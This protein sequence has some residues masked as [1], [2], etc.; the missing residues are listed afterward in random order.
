M[1]NSLCG[2]VTVML[3]EVRVMLKAT[4]CGCSTKEIRMLFS[5]SDH[6]IPDAKIQVEEF[7]LVKVHGYL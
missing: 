5:D 7:E 4:L 6:F 2:S 1:R 3:H